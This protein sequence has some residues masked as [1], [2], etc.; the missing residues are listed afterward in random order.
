MDEDAS[1]AFIRALASN[2]MPPPRISTSPPMC[3][4]PAYPRERLPRAQP[5][6]G[7]PTDE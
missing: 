3:H 2:Q 4:C 1:Q 7:D 5:S 6:A